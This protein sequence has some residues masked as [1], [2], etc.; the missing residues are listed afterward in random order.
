MLIVMKPGAAASEIDAVVNVV[1]AV[2]FRAHPMPGATRTAIGAARSL[3]ALGRPLPPPPEEARLRGRRHSKARDAAAISHHYDVSNDFY[4]LILGS[5]M[6][7]SRACASRP[8]RSR[9]QCS[10]VV[11]GFFVDAFGN[12]ERRLTRSRASA[13]KVGKL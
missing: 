11:R 5:T 13:K 7:Y 6:T 12:L 2:G 4:R 10:K 8:S 1:E 3:G 9:R